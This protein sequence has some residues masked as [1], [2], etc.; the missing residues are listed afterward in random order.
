MPK[1]STAKMLAVRQKPDGNAL[2]VTGAALSLVALFVSGN[3][4]IAAGL[5]RAANFAASAG[6]GKSRSRHARIDFRRTEQANDKCE[7]N[8]K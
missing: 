6:L 8:S 2:P 4:A 1:R 5:S 3:T 7:R